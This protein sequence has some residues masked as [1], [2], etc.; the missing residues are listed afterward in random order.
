MAETREDIRR[1]R[2]RA[3]AAIIPLAA[4]VAALAAAPWLLSD[5]GLALMVN[6][7]SYLVLTIAWALFSGTTRLVSLATSA[8]FG[9]G[10][11]TVAML[12]KVLPLYATFAVAIGV[13]AATALVVGV[14]TLRIA[15]MFFVIFG[16]GLS[17]MIRE[18]MV[19]WEINQ[20]HTMGRYVYVP[21][22]TTMIYEHLLGLAVLVF[23]VGWQLRRS[24]LGLALLVIGED[25]TVARQ[26]G[27]NVPFAKV[28]IFIV[29]AIFMTLTGAL[30]APRFGFINPNF[31]FNPLVSFVVV[32]MAILG[33]LRR[34]WGPVLGVIPLI[35]LSDL[36]QTEFPF[37]FSVFLGL[38][39]M[40]IVY[41]LPRG[42]S[43]LLD[44]GWEALGRPI[45][46]PRGLAGPVLDAWTWLSRPISLPRGIAG[47]IEDRWEKILPRPAER[48]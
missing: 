21:F 15:G 46:L 33:G 41:F 19:W 1:R 31:A 6:V 34:L 23:L 45:E 11:Y 48:R 47:A 43:G 7:T 35:I 32:I 4:L 44:D 40:V 24:R 29:S 42:L 27:I 39:F 16:F 26:V 5:Y 14:L 36:L 18:L 9:I 28:T 38:V 2:N 20:T 12:I 22:S 13:G 30:M 17:E 3:T 37:W 8:F 25:E 10:M